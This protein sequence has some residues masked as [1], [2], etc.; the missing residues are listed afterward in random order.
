MIVGGCGDRQLGPVHNGCEASGLH[1]P[2]LVGVVPSGQ[3]HRLAAKIS[4]VQHLPFTTSAPSGQPL[5]G[6]QTPSPIGRVPSR[7][8]AHRLADAV[9]DVTRAFRASARVAS[10]KPS[11]VRSRSV[12]CIFRLRRAACLPDSRSS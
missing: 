6:W 10:L 11:R 5:T 1:I 3:P 8:A 12:A 2:S 9:P 7:A 4:R